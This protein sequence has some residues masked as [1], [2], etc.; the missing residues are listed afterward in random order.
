MSKAIRL[1][2]WSFVVLFAIFLFATAQE[3]DILLLDGKKYF[4]YTNPLA[5]FLSKNPGKL[6]KSDVVS[7]NNWRGYVATWEVK[8]DRLVL[9]DVGIEHAI[10]KPGE[11]GFS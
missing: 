1:V 11:Q 2:V 5:P 6:P 4:I 3:G 9:V 10:S 8:S 7:S